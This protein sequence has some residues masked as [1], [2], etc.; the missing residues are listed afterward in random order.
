MEPVD[1][2]NMGTVIIPVVPECR[3]QVV[4]AGLTDTGSVQS[5]RVIENIQDTLLRECSGELRYEWIVAL[6]LGGKHTFFAKGFQEN[7]IDIVRIV[8][9]HEE[10]DEI[11][12]E[13]ETSP[14]VY[15]E[16]ELPEWANHIEWFKSSKESVLNTHKDA[17]KERTRYGK[18]TQ[19]SSEQQRRVPVDPPSRKGDAVFWC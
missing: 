5:V 19:E 12:G 4:S 16:E 18:A 9:P 1:I 14:V 3:V 8:V 6:V 15:K 13:Y 11:A 2:T 10:F 7:D 17:V